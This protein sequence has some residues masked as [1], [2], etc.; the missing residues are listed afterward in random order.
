[1]SFLVPMALRVCRLACAGLLAAAAAHANEP[2]AQ[3]VRPALGA[4]LQQAEALIGQ[5]RAAEAL[6]KVRDA[7][8][9]ASDLTPYERYIV[10][11]MKAAAASRADQSA[12]AL[13]AI[14]A[15]IATGH[16]RGAQQVELIESLVQGAYR[17]KDY[18]RAVR[19]AERYRA[20]GGTKP[21]VES[22][23]IHALHLSGDHAAAAA[24]LSA[25]VKADDEA[26]RAP[27]ER[28]LQV[29]FHAQRQMNDAA[30]ATATM[31]RLA[32]RY[33]KPAYWAE[34]IGRV[35]ERAI[36][37]RLRLDLLRL[38][39]ATGA[40]SNVENQVALAHLAL[41]AGFAGEAANVLEEAA[42]LGSPD[43][44]R[45]QALRDRARKQAAEDAAAQKGDLATASAA[46]DGNGLAMLGQA[47]AAQ[48][49]FEAGI[50]LMEQGL[51]RGGLRRADEVKL[52][53]GQAQA[54]AG[55]GPAAARTLSSLVGGKDGAAALARLWTLYAN[56][57]SAGS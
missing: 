28:D 2:P 47:A 35:D 11:R 5:G 57:A 36:G 22:V 51:A 32:T 1:M 6:D 12:L 16:L 44:A 31:E 37:D 17:G 56:R 20:E 52:R 50:A 27:A 43:A 23:R 13:E 42:T 49:R 3:T 29:L 33:P 15:A 34:L 21:E 30:G 25:K 48:G 24:A 53:L 19:W 41:H 18:A 26:G 9:A 10:S 54:L 7:E 45:H 39:R 14:E 38:A 55:Q 46:K 4:P 40:L 8:N